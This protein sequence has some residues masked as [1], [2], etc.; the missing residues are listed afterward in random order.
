VITEVGWRGLNSATQT[1]ST[2]FLEIYNPTLFSVD[3]SNYYI[4]DVNGYSA[5]P[6]TGMIDIAASTTDF[7]MRFPAGASIGPGQVQVI[8]VDGG[9]YKRGTGVDATYMMFNAGGA[10]TAQLMRDVATNKGAGYPGFGFFTNGGEFVWLFCWDGTT[11]LVCD[12]DLVYWPQTPAAGSSNSPSLKTSAMCQDGP[13]GD[14]ASSCYVNDNGPLNKGLITPANG[15]GTRQRPTG[16]EVETGI[17][18]GNGCFSIPV[19]V[20]PT[21]WGHVK[22]LYH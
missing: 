13:D 6:V 22:A 16:P 15:A 5:L 7:A 20:V 4:S 12:L 8:A 10:T 17:I 11:D 14:V 3:L 1:D 19:P 2:E 9:R 18:N 21:T